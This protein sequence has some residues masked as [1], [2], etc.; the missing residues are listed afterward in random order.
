MDHPRPIDEEFVTD[1]ENGS[2]EQKEFR[3]LCDQFMY[4]DD[5]V[6]KLSIIDP[7]TVKN[8]CA[9]NILKVVI[10][11][12]MEGE[13]AEGK[14]MGKEKRKKASS[15]KKPPK[16]PRP[17]R[18]FSLDAAD[19]KFIKEIAELAMIKRARITRMKALKQKKAL[20]ASSSSSSSSMSGSLFAMLFTV[21]FVLMIVLQGTS[22]RSSGVTSQ[23]SPQTA[24]T[25]ENGLV[26]I[27]EQLNPSASDYILPHSKSSILSQKITGSASNGRKITVAS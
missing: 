18:G 4:V 24:Q 23:R 5:S 25:N 9:E 21:I 7:A 6:V 14:K 20:K 3:K 10:D 1:L 13:K 2:L 11:S 26:F 19:Q 22:Y 15:A 16:P 12:Q 8:G 17:P 27:Q